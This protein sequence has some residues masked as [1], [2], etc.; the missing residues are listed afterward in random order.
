MDH[1]VL[2]RSLV[3]LF[4]V[5]VTAAA[6]AAAGQA[7]QQP[8]RPD[9]VPM[10]IAIKLA[11]G[12]YDD[13]GPGSCTHAPKASIYG[14]VSQMWTAR[15]QTDKRSLSLTLWRPL[16]GSA[17]MFTLAVNDRHSVSITTVRGGQPS[18]SGTVKLEPQGK[19]G[20]FRVQAKGP[21][22]EAVTGTI[23]CEAF[24]PHVAEGG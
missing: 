24:M 8:A 15:H 6:V 14:V 5:A 17:E 12:S 11:A 3:P 23:R 21:G 10:E 1:R 19:G 16:D 4:V 9:T 7:R 18:G 2:R 20:T 22:G 13:Q